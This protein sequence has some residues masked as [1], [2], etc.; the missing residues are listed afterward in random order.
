MTFT[1][2]ARKKAEV[3]WKASFEH[4]FIRELAIGDLSPTVFRYYLLQDRYYLEHFGKLYDLIAEQADDPEVRASLKEHAAN[5][6][7]GE[8]AVRE[9]FFSELKIT[10][11]EIEE[12]AI[13]PTAY[14]YVSHMYR[15]LID[16]TVNTAFAGML[17]C[18]WLYQEIGSQ[19]IEAG[20]PNPLYQRWIE[21]YADAVEEVEKER[22]LLDR[23]YQESSVDEQQQMIE[24]FVI[25][26]KME[27]DFW[28]MAL[29]LE[30]W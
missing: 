30:Q 11:Q 9:T 22:Q 16:G 2:L 28:E 21:T 7:L 10:E 6:E 12:T 5:L 29:T 14:H 1:E 23:L 19:L 8:M 27:C 25:S 3:Y 4:P 24:A 18:A 13:A 17:P 26:S 20:S 15:Q